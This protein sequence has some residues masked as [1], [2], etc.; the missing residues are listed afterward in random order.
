VP[1]KTHML[2]DHITCTTPPC[3][4]K[5]AHAHGTVCELHVEPSKASALA[6]DE[7]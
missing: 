1:Y 5:N 6:K 2:A 4:D 3:Q 7:L